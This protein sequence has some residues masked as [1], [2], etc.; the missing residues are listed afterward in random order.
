MGLAAEVG[1]E[2]EREQVHLYQDI[3]CEPLSPLHQA[4]FSFQLRVVFRLK[5]PQPLLSETKR[6]K[7]PPFM[8]GSVAAMVGIASGAK[9][10]C[11]NCSVSVF[12]FVRV[13][14]TQQ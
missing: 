8:Y 4:R 5:H 13:Y 6:S 2:G 1:P 9:P 10:S 3:D 14:H 11:C 12:N 7:L